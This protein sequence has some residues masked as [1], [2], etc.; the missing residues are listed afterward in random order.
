[1]TIGVPIVTCLHSV[2]RIHKVRVC[3]RIRRIHKAIVTNCVCVFALRG[4]VN[5]KFIIYKIIWIGRECQRALRFHIR[6]WMIIIYYL[7]M[8]SG[9]IHSVDL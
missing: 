7:L 9:K 3:V 2:R 5:S 1:M 4:V 6:T 8:D